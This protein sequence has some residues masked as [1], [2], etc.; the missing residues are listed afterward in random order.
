VR[1]VGSAGDGRFHRLNLG[2]D[3][4]DNDDLGFALRAAP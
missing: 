1:C 4:D 2:G 3:V